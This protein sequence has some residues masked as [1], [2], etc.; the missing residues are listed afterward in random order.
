MKNLRLLFL[1]FLT[2]IPVFVFFVQVISSNKEEPAPI[3][4]EIDSAVTEEGTTVTEEGTTITEE[5]SPHSESEFTVEEGYIREVKG[6]SNDNEVVK[7]EQFIICP[8]CTGTGVVEKN[9]DYCDRNSDC[10]PLISGGYVVYESA[11]YI[12]NK[13]GFDK[14]EKCERCKGR[15]TKKIH[16]SVCEGYG[17]VK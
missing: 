7:K 14:C 6:I 15:G 5:S 16:C 8:N 2:V 4:T 9:C 10:G 17:R 1:A 12:M 11:K 3:D 13:T